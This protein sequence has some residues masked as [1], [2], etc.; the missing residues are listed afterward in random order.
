M[1]IKYDLFLS[2]LNS[3]G[4]SVK[5]EDFKQLISSLKEAEPVHDDVLYEKIKLVLKLDVFDVYQVA[6]A[7]KKVDVIVSEDG[8]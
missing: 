7:L 8:L 6:L 2:L 4:K 1:E 5:I 3:K